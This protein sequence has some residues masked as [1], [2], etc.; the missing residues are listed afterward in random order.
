MR[1]VDDVAGGTCLTLLGERGQR[2]NLR[3][4]NGVVNILSV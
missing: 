3:V 2:R 1:V 4:V